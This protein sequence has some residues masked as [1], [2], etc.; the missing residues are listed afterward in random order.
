MR[1]STKLKKKQKLAQ[2]LAIK[3]LKDKPNWKPASGFKYIEDV[4]VGELVDTYYGL[5]AV[6]IEQS[7]VST[8]V[9][10]LIKRYPNDKELGGRIRTFVRA[11]LDGEPTT[12]DEYN[13][14]AN[15]EVR[16]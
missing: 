13:F 12:A 11:L 7:S 2:A 1:L 14:E 10:Q 6:V 3:A 9:E 16:K 8:S 15:I 4:P 5:R